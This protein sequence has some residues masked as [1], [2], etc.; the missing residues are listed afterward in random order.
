MVK[1]KSLECKSVTDSY[2]T[3]TSLIRKG[4]LS[5]TAKNLAAASAFA[6]GAL[7]DAHA[8][9]SVSVSWASPIPI[10]TVFHNSTNQQQQ[11]TVA[12]FEINWGTTNI[13]D[14][15]TNLYRDGAAWTGV[16]T[17]W[18]SNIPATAT[19]LVINGLK[20][21][22]TY[23]FAFDVFFAGPQGPAGTS[24]WFAPLSQQFQYPLAPF[25]PS[26]LKAEGAYLDYILDFY[27]EPSPL[28][29]DPRYL[30]SVG[31]GQLKLR[32]RVDKVVEAKPKRPEQ[33]LDL[34]T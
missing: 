19:N 30:N 25:P 22:T 21:G 14:V 32:L 27:S 4:R 34:K 20:E 5:T 17:N 18:V 33:K 26:D 11:F 2:G 3:V 12:G 31:A 1:A 16:N 13:N 6:L 24:K 7:Y 9:Y 10:S 8:D 29:K 28:S 23:Y 15:N